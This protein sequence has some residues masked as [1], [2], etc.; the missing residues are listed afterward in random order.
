MTKRWQQHYRAQLVAMTALAMV[1]LTCSGCIALAVGAAG[2]IAGATYVLGKLTDELN[3]EVPVVHAAATQAMKELDLKVSEDRSDK[4]TAHME[5][6]F[7]DGTNVWIDMQSI[8]E[9]RA[10]LTIRVGVTGDEVR[11]RKIDE[12][13][14]QNLT[15][16]AA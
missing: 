4:L 1:V 12:A 14:R 9:G 15:H 7:A 11:A 10:K 13:I 6:E 8:A 3:H 16:G 2:G 5:S